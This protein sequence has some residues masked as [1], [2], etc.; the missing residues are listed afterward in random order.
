TVAC[1]TT[2]TLACSSNNLAA[3]DVCDNLDNNCN[4]TTDENFGVS[5]SVT[6]TGAL[7]AP[8]NGKY[9]GLTCGTGSCGSGTVV[10]G[11]T[12]TLACSSNNLVGVENCDEL[13]NDCDGSTDETYT[14]GGTFSMTDALFSDDNGKH[15]GDVCGIG[16]CAGGT[17][18][19]APSTTGLICTTNLLATTD[20]C[21]AL[22]NNCNGFTDENFVTGGS[23]PLAG[24]LYAADNGKFKGVSCGTGPCQGGTV[25]C[26]GSKLALVCSSEGAATSELC[27]DLDNDC[28]GS[29]DETFAALVTALFAGDI[30]KAKNSDCGVGLCEG[31]KV[32]CNV[33]GTALACTS[34]SSALGAEACNR[35][36]DTCNG[37]TDEGFPDLD[38]D[39]I[40]DCVD[41]CVDVD[42]DG[43]GRVGQNA[44]C[45]DAKAGVTDCDD[46]TGNTA[47]P[48]HDN[49]CVVEGRD[50]CVGGLVIG[51]NDNCPLNANATQVDADRDAIG[52]DCDPIP[53]GCM[54]YDICGD[55]LDNNCDGSTDEATCVQARVL[56]V[57]AGADGAPADYATR[58]TLDHKGLVDSGVSNANG[59]DVRVFYKSQT[60]TCSDQNPALC[61]V[62]IDRVADQKAANTWNTA[63]TVVWFPL[64]AAIAAN[65]SDANYLVFFNV[66]TGSPLADEKNVFWFADYFDRANANAVG[67]PW[68]ETEGAEGYATITSSALAFPGAEDNRVETPRVQAP[69]TAVSSGTWKWV[70][71]FDFTRT[72][73]STYQMLM[74]LGD[75]A[76][77]STA[78]LDGNRATYPNEGVG[79]SLLWSSSTVRASFTTAEAV[80]GAQTLTGS[81]PTFTQI[82]QVNALSEIEVEFQPGANTYT[83]SVNGGAASAAFSFG[84]TGVTSLN[85]I[86]LITDDISATNGGNRAFPY[87]YLRRSLG[88]S[89]KEPATALSLTTVGSDCTLSDASL[90]ARYLLNESSGTAIADSSG[91]GT[92]HNLTLTAVSASPTLAP[93][94]GIPGFG[95]LSFTTAAGN[96]RANSTTEYLNAG[97]D[98][99]VSG[100]TTALNG[101]TVATMEVVFNSTDS[102][103][104]EA[105]AQYIAGLFN[106]SSGS[107]AR[108]SLQTLSGTVLQASVG[109]NGSASTGTTPTVSS[110]KWTVNFATARRIV[111]HLVY[112]SALANNADKLVVYQD[113][114]KLTQSS[115]PTATI[116]TSNVLRL[117][118]SQANNFENQGRV[119]IGNDYDLGNSLAGKVGYVAFYKVAMDASTVAKQ[120]KILKRKDD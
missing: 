83:V 88:S 45:L 20:L 59:S 26:A 14:P 1:A 107:Q 104:A 50:T 37:S 65:A 41:T 120:A 43:W 58:L 103:G 91:V 96:G 99:F 66:Q 101:S 63:S 18:V 119:V 61:Y 40:A 48:D 110:A 38:A 74:Q 28:D 76:Q 46:T 80:L 114:V 117:V 51:C 49:I 85:T 90:V 69:F 86:R 7:Y 17:V 3:S 67:S 77:L 113:G 70:F 68:V 60:T 19:C 92:A 108:F 84:A 24:A 89:A 52:D 36:D 78:S 94:A 73:G 35:V 15:K 13:D 27:D 39:G 71:G 81:T 23:S 109:N 75:S 95:A 115:P 54:P 21:D 57:T 97:S 116:T 30:G 55:C 112:N 93:L 8:D 105:A 34:E 22:D 47:D 53:A 118:G 72:T 62:E 25:A 42:G 6:V 79:P 44:G 98:K 87:V 32:L 12:S 106:E 11:T 100:A 33:A 31:G 2:S 29:T 64:E 5:G 56:T 102:R 9:K 4:G 111:L 10:C 82:S 16:P